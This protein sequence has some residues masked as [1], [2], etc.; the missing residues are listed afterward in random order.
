MNEAFNARRSSRRSFLAG[1]ILLGLSAA[2]G[3]SLSSPAP[4]AA[5][6]R[7]T[8]DGWRFCVNCFELFL[9]DI[10]VNE[11]RCPQNSGTHQPAGWTFRL[12]Y[13]DSQ[14]GVGESSNIQANWRHCYRCSSL[15]WGPSATK[16]CPLW[17]GGDHQ[18]LNPYSPYPPRQFLLTHDVGQ[19]SGWQ[20]RWR[21]CFKCSALFFDGYAQKGLCP[22]DYVY[23]HTAAGYDF[24]MPV[25]AY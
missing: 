11:S 8:S 18:W 9:F 17:P 25:S 5:E 15:F 14:S 2:A 20:N 13:N 4:A 7:W 22:F 12:T 24:A 3:E 1:G 10:T 21:F 19:P 6:P 16:R 23:G